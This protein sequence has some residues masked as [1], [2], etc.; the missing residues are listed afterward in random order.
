M[1]RSILFLLAFAVLLFLPAGGSAASGP[2]APGSEE[3]PKEAAR[4]LDAA[5]AEA[6]SLQPRRRPPF[7]AGPRSQGPRRSEPTYGL[8][9]HSGFRMLAVESALFDDN[10]FDF[11]VE[12]GDFLA[13]RFGVEGDFALLP[14]FAVTL[15]VESGSATSTSSYLDFVHDDGGEILHDSELSIT[16]FTLGGRL[17]LGPPTAR[18]RGYLAAGV[19]GMIYQYWEDGEFIDGATF[20]IFYDYYEERSFQLGFFAGVGGEMPLFRTR[21]GYGALFVEYRYAASRGE[22]GDGFEG[23]GDLRLDRSGALIGLRVRF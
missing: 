1:P 5:A 18:V 16:E 6:R 14:R 8:S 2:D 20:D 21:L 4:L 10:E 9:F 11:G 3:D 12:A 22:H 19:T 23:F 13:A 15:G 7:G 17:L